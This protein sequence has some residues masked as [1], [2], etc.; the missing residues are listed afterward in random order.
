LSDHSA[1]PHPVPLTA[2]SAKDKVRR[3]REQKGGMLDGGASA[4]APVGGGLTPAE[5]RPPK[6]AKTTSASDPLSC[7]LAFRFPDRSVLKAPPFP[8]GALL[9]DAFAVVKAVRTSAHGLP[10]D[11]FCPRGLW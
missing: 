11:H 9:A 3:Q 10:A 2:G 4:S 1:C 8:G 7:R 5:K 6:S